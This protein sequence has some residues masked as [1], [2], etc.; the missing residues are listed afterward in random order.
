MTPAR[1][2]RADAR[3]TLASLGSGARACF[4]RVQAGT[5]LRTRL[6]AMGLRPGAEL[7]VVHSGGRGPFVLA[8]EG[9]RI[10]LGRGMAHQVL[11]TVL[12]TASSGHAA[13]E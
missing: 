12:E 7:R 9:S 10:V 4:E 2:R 3:V 6:V 13:E 8:V 5:A 1:A 11:V